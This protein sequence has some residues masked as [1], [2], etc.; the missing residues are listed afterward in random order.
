MSFVFD[1]AKNSPS[2]MCV[3][4]MGGVTHIH[5]YILKFVDKVIRFWIQK[6]WQQVFLNFP[7]KHKSNHMV[8]HSSIPR[9]ID[10]SIL[11]IFIYKCCFEHVNNF[12]QGCRQLPSNLI[13]MSWIITKSRKIQLDS[14]KCT[15]ITQKIK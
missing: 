9:S 13:K 15:K 11:C 12:Q 1:M 4:I 7:S 14:Y 2:W 5:K 10:L 3:L 8:Y 6:Y